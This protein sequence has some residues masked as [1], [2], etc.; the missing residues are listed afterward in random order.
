MKF[1]RLFA[2]A[3]MAA[4]CVG[5]LQNA[6]RAQNYPARPIIMVVAF[7]PGGPTDSLARLVADKLG[8]KI[9]ERV[10]VENRPGAGGNIGYEMVAKAPADGYT[11]AF[12]DPSLTVNPSLY[13]TVKYNPERDFTPVSL[14]VRGPT[15]MV[16]PASLGV[17]TVSEFIALARAKP[18][19]LTYGSAGTGTPPHLNAELFKGAEHLDIVHSPYKGAAP[20][21]VDLIAGRIDVMFLNIGSAFGQI[22]AGKLR[23]LAVSGSSR[24]SS[25]PQVPTFAEAGVRLPEL[26]P[27]TW[28]GVVAPA[29]LPAEVLLKLNTAL[30]AALADPNLRER[31]ATFN[32]D[33]ILGSAEEFA[34]LIKAESAKWADVIKR[35]K[36]TAE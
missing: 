17:N 5:T 11:L 28:W 13:A 30:Q 29:G 3:A 33:P 12:A 26:D 25:L 8:E 34:A 9:G 23:G 24:V 27:G 10:A 18:G 35:G 4:V 32:V 1:A 31:L 2:L 6:S 15:V 19:A 16:V 20:A 14:A 7:A 21:V 36:I 22:Q